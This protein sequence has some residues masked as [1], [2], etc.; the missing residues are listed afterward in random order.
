[1]AIRLWRWTSLATISLLAIGVSVACGPMSLPVLQSGGDAGGVAGVAQPAPIAAQSVAH[2]TPTPAKARPGAVRSVPVKRDS[3]TE[4]LSLDGMATAQTQEPIMYGWRAIVDDV[5]VKGGQS[6]QQGDILVEFSQGDAPKTLVTARAALQTSLGNLALAQAQAESSQAAT[7]QRAAAEQQRQQQA[8][9]D[10]Q[11]ALTRA[12]DNLVKVQAGKTATERQVADTAVTDYGT[13]NLVTAQRALD[14]ALAGPGENTIRVA[15]REVANYQI[16][17]TRAQADLDAFTNGPDPATL[18]TAQAAIQRAQSQIQLAQAA[19]IDPKA[20]DPAVAKIQHD[21]SIQDAQ[22]ALDNADAQVTKL[23]QP[24]ADVDVQSSRFRVLDAQTNLSTAQAKLDALQA[25]PDQAAIEAAQHQLEA[26]KHALSEVQA[27]RD[28][29]YSHPTPAELNQAQDQVRAAQKALDNARQ[30]AP[31]TDAPGPDITALQ[32]V[33]SQDQAD[34]AAAEQALENTHLRA[35]FDG[36]VVSVKTKPGDTPAP[37]RP[38]VMMA[39]PVPPVV[40]VDLDDTQAGR[41][42]VGQPARIQIGTGT[43]SGSADAT[44]TSVTPAAQDGSV[45]ASASL[46]ALWA[47]GQ[48][49]RLG[50]PVQVTVSLGGK[51][52]VLVVPKSAVHQ[53]GGRTTVEVQDGTIRRLVSVQ[54]GITAADTIEI[55]SG[56]SEGQLVLAGPV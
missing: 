18:R 42:A 12:Q 28:E 9:L 45:G 3:L 4:T 16:A 48:S 13:T 20:P 36:T 10:A 34:L 50:T 21:N 54:V 30:A 19:K 35:P 43:S 17:L 47:E 26:T 33:I 41:L 44:V 14:A 27:I 7:A 31:V 2:A 46:A 51:Q 40:R 15:Q 25:G 32:K 5:K 39:R 24:P 29:V 56:L 55:V 38:V 6:V 23:K 49:P 52:D 22:A 1:M 37:S 8:V 11:V 53:S